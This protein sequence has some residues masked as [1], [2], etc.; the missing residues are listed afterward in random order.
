MPSQAKAIASMGVNAIGVIGVKE[1][2]RFVN[3][4]QRRKIFSTLRSYDQ[5]LERVLV[6]ADLDDSEFESLLK[7]DETPNVIQLHGDETE[8]RCNY[9]RKKYQQ[10]KWWK[11]FRIRN[12][13]DLIFL[14]K[15]KNNVDAILIDAWSSLAKG[16][17]GERVPIDLLKGFKCEIPWWLA[18]GI[19]EEWVPKILKEVQPYGL[20]ASSKLEVSPGIKDLKKVE[21]LLKAIRKN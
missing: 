17:T 20:D 6:V 9:L 15:Y 5:N 4:Y 19:S 16:G 18:G 2:P 13:K 8:L 1:S 7:G 3:S 14:E 10:I 12:Q 21:S 11:A